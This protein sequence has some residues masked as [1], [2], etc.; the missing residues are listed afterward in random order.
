MKRLIIVFITWMLVGVTVTA[1]W[2]AGPAKP[3]IEAEMP[4]CYA[5]IGG[6][7]II[8]FTNAFRRLPQRWAP[9]LLFPHP[10]Y[11]PWQVPLPVR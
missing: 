9:G 2:A 8:L 5:Y 10:N 7:G 6:D 1:A 11:V 4:D 3:V